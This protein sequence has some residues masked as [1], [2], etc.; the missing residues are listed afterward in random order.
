MRNPLAG[1]DM[2]KVVA[3][4]YGLEKTLVEKLQ[5]ILK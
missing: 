1:E 4:A 3:R 5:E 2:E